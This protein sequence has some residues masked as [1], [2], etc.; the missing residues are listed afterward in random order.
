G[1]GA[2]APPPEG[3]NTAGVLCCS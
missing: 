3:M 2:V 1:S